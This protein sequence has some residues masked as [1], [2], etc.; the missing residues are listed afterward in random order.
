M[1]TNFKFVLMSA[2]ALLSLGLASCSSSDEAENVNPTF[3]GKAVKTS[4]T[5]SVSDVKGTRMSKES[6]QEAMPD[7]P[8]QGMEDIYLFPAKAAITGATTVTEGYI[9]LPSFNAFD[10][11][12]G[13][14]F[15]D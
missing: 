9:N 6:V 11:A 2:T 12:G 1:R 5:I 13:A 3:D 4:F 14:G 10:D 8:F 7:V 15:D